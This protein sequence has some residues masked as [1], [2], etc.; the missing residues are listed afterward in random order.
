MSD[1]A[2]GQFVEEL[3]VIGAVALIVM[4]PPVWS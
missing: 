3:V 1:I 2:G 4:A